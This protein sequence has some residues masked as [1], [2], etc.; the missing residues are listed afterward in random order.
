VEAAQSW[1]RVQQQ[2]TCPLTSYG[3]AV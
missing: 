3:P 1:T 2:H